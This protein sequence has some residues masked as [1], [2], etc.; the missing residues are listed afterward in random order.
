[1]STERSPKTKPRRKRSRERGK[2]RFGGFSVMVFKD[3]LPAH[4]RHI[5]RYVQDIR[6]GLIKDLGGEANMTTGQRI[7]VDRITQGLAIVRLIE[8]HVRELGLL[9]H[10]EGFLHPTLSDHYL[11]WQ[12]SIH[13]ALTL[14][15]V[16]RRQQD[17]GPTWAEVVAEVK[18]ER[19]AQDAERALPA[20][21][22]GQDADGT[23]DPAG[24]QGKPEGLAED[25]EDDALVADLEKDKEGSHGA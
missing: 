15:G 25:A 2:V 10:P 9:D 14:L 12:T 6:D 19:E 11:R 21:E 4:R 20:H 16:E 5:A 1:M 13:K 3:Q 7:L 23:A 24:C 17:T 8:E 22:A 18:A